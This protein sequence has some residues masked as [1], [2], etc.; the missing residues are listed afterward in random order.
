MIFLTVV[1]VSEEFLLVRIDN[2]QKLACTKNHT[3]PV[4][5]ILFFFG[6]RNLTRNDT[7]KAVINVTILKCI[8]GKQN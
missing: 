7:Q 1:K 6:H 5:Q 8:A 2:D 3:Q 4:S